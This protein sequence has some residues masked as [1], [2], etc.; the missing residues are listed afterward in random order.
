[1]T[2]ST[3]YREF[4]ADCYRLASKIKKEKHRAILQEIARQWEKLAQET[5][6]A[7]AQS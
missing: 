3:Q 2:T 5:E 6:A 7:E 1:M 4:A